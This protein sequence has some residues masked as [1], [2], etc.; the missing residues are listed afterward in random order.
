MGNEQ[1]VE[2]EPFPQLD[3]QYLIED[4]IEYPVSFNGKMKFKL[5]LPAEMHP[6]AIEELILQEKRVINHLDGNNPKKIIIVP[7]KII[8]IVT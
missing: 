1:S 7:K 5:L 8:N 4:E 6:K 3:E 2:E